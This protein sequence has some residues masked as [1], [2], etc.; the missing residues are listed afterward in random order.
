[1]RVFHGIC[2]I[3]AQNSKV[4]L[5]YTMQLYTV[6][7]IEHY[8]TENFWKVAI[9]LEGI[10]GDHLGLAVLGWLSLFTISFPWLETMILVIKIRNLK[11]NMYFIHHGW[12]IISE[13]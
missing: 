6:V 2:Q 12:M 1:M 5:T 10:F 13:V 4:Q 7:G 8:I 9:K 11:F 3:Y